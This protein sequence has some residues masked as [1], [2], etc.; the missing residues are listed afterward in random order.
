MVNPIIKFGIPIVAILTVALF[1]RQASATSL[2]QAGQDVGAG[3]SGIGSAIEN[4]G[5]GIGSV[6]ANIL[7]GFGQGLSGLSAG[8]KSFTSLFGQGGWATPT[9]VESGA[10]NPVVRQ[11]FEAP[12]VASTST[13]ASSN[14]ENLA[15]SSSAYGIRQR[16]GF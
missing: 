15:S 11:R 1:L 12:F 7:G 5:A 10:T 4:L 16:L 13:T 14:A 9:S 2:G 6:P 8:I 3:G